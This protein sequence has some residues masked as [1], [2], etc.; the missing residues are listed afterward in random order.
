MRE[1]GESFKGGGQEGRAL[2]LLDDREVEDEEM[3]ERLGL[4]SKWEGKS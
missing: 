1:P 3:L 4:L 2:G